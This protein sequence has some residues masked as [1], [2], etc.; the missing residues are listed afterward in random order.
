MGTKVCDGGGAGRAMGSLVD[1]FIG[2]LMADLQAASLDALLPELFA[3]RPRSFSCQ[4]EIARQ[5]FL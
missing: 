4:G 1:A 2:S 5:I 3:A